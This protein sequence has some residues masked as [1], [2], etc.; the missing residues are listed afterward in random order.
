MSEGS[1]RSLELMQ[2]R[3]GRVHVKRFQAQQSQ[4]TN[5]R[6]ARA[7]P[8]TGTHTYSHSL[9]GGLLGSLVL[10]AAGKWVPAGFLTR[11]QAGNAV[12][13]AV[14]VPLHWLDLHLCRFCGVLRSVA[15]LRAV[16]GWESAVGLGPIGSHAPCC[17]QDVK[18]LHAWFPALWWRTMQPC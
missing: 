6:S 15:G 1:E 16:E 4:G 9:A 11:Q 18:G 7:V 13:L 17:S 5:T 3:A 12:A 8:T 2:A 14:A 10:F